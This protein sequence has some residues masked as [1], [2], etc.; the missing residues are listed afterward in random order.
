MAACR[1]AGALTTSR[2]T[3]AFWLALASVLARRTAASSSHTGSSIAASAPL[4]PAATGHGWA[5]TDPAC[6]HDHTSSV[7]NGMN[8][9]NRRWMVCSAERSAA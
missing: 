5:C 2:S 7:T 1:L 6:H 9:A 4:A 8:G 3:A